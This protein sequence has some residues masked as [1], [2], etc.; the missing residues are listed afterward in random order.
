[1]YTYLFMNTT[2]NIY[3]CRLE[4]IQQHPGKDNRAIS[5]LL[6]EAWK[7]LP[8]EDREKYTQKAKVTY[9]IIKIVKYFIKDHIDILR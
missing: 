4:L 2:N 3:N 7:N 9:A 6:G 8:L 5:V 1:M